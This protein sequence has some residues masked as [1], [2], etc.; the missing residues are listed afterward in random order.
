MLDLAAGQLPASGQVGG[1]AAARG[2]QAAAVEQGGADHHGPS[3]HGRR[4]R[5]GRHEAEP[6]GGSGAHGA[7]GRPRR[8]SAPVVRA[9][10]PRRSS[11]PYERGRS[12]AAAVPVLPETLDYVE[13][14]VPRILEAVGDLLRLGLGRVPADAVLIAVV[15]LP[16]DDPGQ[17]S[18]AL[19]H[20]P[21][22]PHRA[23]HPFRHHGTPIPSRALAGPRLRK[24]QYAYARAY[25]QP[26]LSEY[27]FS[28]R[29]THPARPA[30]AHKNECALGET[31]GRIPS[32]PA[33]T[34]EN[35]RVTAS[36]TQPGDPRHRR[37]HLPREPAMCARSLRDLRVV[38]DPHRTGR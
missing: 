26:S 36:V 38:Y 29:G 14:L 4:G 15:V 9:G 34:C 11:A 7:A 31:T 20:G 30:G 37:I 33:P 10:C 2:E 6:T 22:R 32:E 28:Q 18:R 8:S 12:A 1:R 16:Y 25:A 13:P 17:G 5:R 23:L 3:R 19:T 24:P 21:L 35:T 27:A